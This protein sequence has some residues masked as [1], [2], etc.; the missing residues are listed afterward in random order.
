[1]TSDEEISWE[2]T[3]E[4]DCEE[5]L[6]IQVGPCIGSKRAAE[7]DATPCTD[8]SMLSELL[9]KKPRLGKGKGNAE[10]KRAKNVRYDNKTALGRHRSSLAGALLR[11]QNLSGVTND[12]ALNAWILSTF[13]EKFTDKQKYIPFMPPS[14]LQQLSDWISTR[15]QV[16]DFHRN[17]ADPNEENESCVDMGLIGGIISTE[18]IG[19]RLH[20]TCKELCV[21][22]TALFRLVDVKTRL[23]MCLDPQSWKGKDHEDLVKKALMEPGDLLEEHRGKCKI[24]HFT[25]YWIE[26]FQIRHTSI[27][28]SSSTKPLSLVDGAWIHYDPTAR[29]INSPTFV[30]EELRK[31]RN[32][33]YCIACDEVG[34]VADVTSRYEKSPEATIRA[35]C[36]A[37]QSWWISQLQ[38][39]T[40]AKNLT[41]APTRGY[42]HER[43]HEQEHKDEHEHEHEHE[44]GK[45]S[46]DVLVS[47][48]MQEE[49]AFH[50]Q[51]Y[52]QPVPKTLSALKDH[53]LWVVDNCEEAPLKNNE[54]INPSKTKGNLKGIVASK[55]VY[56]RFVVEECKTRTAWKKSLRLVPDDAIPCKIIAK[57]NREGQSYNSEMFGSWQTVEYVL[58]KVSSDGIIPTNVHGN[59]EVWDGC[60]CLVPIGAKFF[61]IAPDLSIDM[62]RKGAKALGIP[63]KDALTGFESQGGARHPKIGGLVVLE[64]DFA[65]LCNAMMEFKQHR[66]QERLS[67]RSEEIEKRWS[68]LVRAALSRK[69][70]YD[71]YNH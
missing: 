67:K 15:F 47:L 52:S 61:S 22:V 39:R 62:I 3:E 59:V 63:F 17:H 35:R 30:V 50:R 19:N 12:G 24:R 42:G 69:Y 55:R 25:R 40:A 51:K 18:E 28:S 36:A 29:K 11:L 32:V 10:G 45:K 31:N 9:R 37:N 20:L 68:R 66:E 27:S 21:V 14:H 23:V 2:E 7:I 41:S 71:T 56:P 65:L 57:K 8:N 38:E 33:E 58:A 43:E 26:I 6:E 49:E 13:P 53:P 1:M 64:K 48:H 16:K 54:C 44:H 46:N 60:E 70:I 34:L 4:L 5:E